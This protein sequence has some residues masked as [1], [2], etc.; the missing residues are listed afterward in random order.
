MPIPKLKTVNA[1]KAEFWRKGQTPKKKKI[2]IKHKIIIALIL[3]ASLG[4][5]SVF[6]IVA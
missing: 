1:P 4:L 5:L 3:L 6:I 2:K